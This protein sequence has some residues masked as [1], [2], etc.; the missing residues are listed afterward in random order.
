M[1]LEHVAEPDPPE[2]AHLLPS[3]WGQTAFDIGANVGQS[4]KTLLMRFDRVISC[5]PAIESYEHLLALARDEPK[6]H[7]LNVAV[8][9]EDGSVELAVQEGHIS[10]GQLTT[11]TMKEQETTHGWGKTLGT[12]HVT[13]VTVDTLARTFGTPDMIKID[14]EGHEVDVLLGATATL[15]KA[16]PDLYVEIHNAPLGDKCLGILRKYYDRRLI[17]EV[18]HPHYRP[19]DWGYGNHYWLMVQD[20]PT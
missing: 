8:S 5:E 4:A 10:R 14:V 19:G 17:Q 13:A 2:I 18:R 3:F 9:A 16:R 1:T 7:P 11:P 6:V 15:E 20:P 12:R